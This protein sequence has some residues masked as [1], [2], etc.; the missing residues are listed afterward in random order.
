MQCEGEMAPLL[1]LININVV[2]GRFKMGADRYAKEA[3]RLKL[4]LDDAHEHGGYEDAKQARD[5]AKREK[6]RLKAERKAERDGPIR[7]AA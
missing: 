6:K 4:M 5:I 1:F 3:R 2:S 7:K